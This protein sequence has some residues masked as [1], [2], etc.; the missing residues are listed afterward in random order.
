[1]AKTTKRDTKPLNVNFYLDSPARLAHY[2]AW[3]RNNGFVAPS[4][5]VNRSALARHALDKLTGY[6][7]K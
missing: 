2:D 5:R 1:M 7:A 4:G 6:K 3:A